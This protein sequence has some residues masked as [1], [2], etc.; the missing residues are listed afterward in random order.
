MLEPPLKTGQNT[1]AFS[2]M[3]HFTQNDEI[4]IIVDQKLHYFLGLFIYFSEINTQ[5]SGVV[6]YEIDNL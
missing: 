1:G 4:F 6:V 3:S 5:I 2:K